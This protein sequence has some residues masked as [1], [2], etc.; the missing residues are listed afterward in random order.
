VAEDTN[1]DVIVVG[2]GFGGTACAALLA[3]RGLR[4]LLL[5][6]NAKA[7]GKAMSLAK[8][9]FTYT[10]WVVITAPAE[11]NPFEKVLEEVGVQGKVEIVKPT[12]GGGRFKNA[13]GEWTD[14]PDGGFGDPDK[15][16][17]HLEVPAE[18]REDALKVMA[19]LATMSAEDI[20]AL[21]DVTFAEWLGSRNVPK[22]I[23]AQ[24]VAPMTDG[25]FVV[26]P[27]ALAASEAIETLQ[28]IFLNPGTLFCKGG[29][30]KIAEAYAYA[31]EAHGGKVVMRARVDEISVERG[32]V[33]GVATDRGHFNAPIVISNAGIQPTVLKLVG[34]EHFDKSYVNYVKELVPSWGFMGARYFL[35]AKVIDDPFGTLFSADSPWSLEKCRRA[36]EGDLPDS[37]CVWFEIPSNYDPDAAPKGK[38]IVLTGHYGP[39]DPMLSEE[40][41]Q[42]W[43][44]LG[45]R[46]L[47]EAYPDFEA[48]IERQ[49]HYS[50]KE[51]SAISRDHVLP[52]QGGE[53]IG[54]GQVVGQDGRYKPAVKAPIRGLFY[55][56]C[57]AGGRGIGTQQAT[58]SGINVANIVHRY[59]MMHKGV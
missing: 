35:D 38:Q 42:K 19:E 44:D 49:E 25:C 28:R 41:K 15:L 32:K 3:K 11:G 34:E 18:E 57:D 20:A 59:F 9:G 31:V 13:A 14:P 55:V 54:L 2:A 56:G 58:D 36:R 1:F 16:M 4:V 22:G 40:E 26:P 27:D 10:A 48:H 33:T 52:G 53:T 50:A 43:W 12:G 37:M 5:D 29:I 46:I 7:G 30:G 23:Y 17:E 21:D 6:K 8:R 51:I 47:F 39:A 45:D 24:L